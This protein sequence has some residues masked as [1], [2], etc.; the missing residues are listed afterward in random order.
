MRSLWIRRILIVLLLLVI[1]VICVPGRRVS[2]VDANSGDSKVVF[3]KFVPFRVKYREHPV[4]DLGF[5]R[6]ERLWVRGGQTT[7]GENGPR[8]LFHG[9]GGREISPGYSA[10][11]AYAELIPVVTGEAF[12][13]AERVAL[14]ERFREIL[15]D[16]GLA[17][18]RTGFNVVDDWDLS[19][20]RVFVRTVDGREFVLHSFE[21]E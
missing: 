16:G 19:G 18:A 17:E 15:V 11:R 12:S 2:W 4:A 6:R 5:S 13:S 7:L 1:V 3:W 10:V 8:S 9:Y 14:V 21:R 20:G